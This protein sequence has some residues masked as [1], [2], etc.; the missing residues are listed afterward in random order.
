LL[1][2]QSRFNKWRS[3]RGG[4][5][6]GDIYVNAMVEPRTADEGIFARLRRAKALVEA[7]D[8]DAATLQFLQLLDCD[9]DGPLRGEVLT[10]LGAALCLSARG[11]PDATAIAQLNHARE[12]LAAAIDCRPRRQAPAA[13]ATTRANLALVYL[14]R[15]QVTDNRDDLMAAHLALDGTEQGLRE[16]GGDT[17]LHDWVRAIRDQLVELSE[18]RAIR[19]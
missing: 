3:I 11:R 14:A 2:N 1:L 16:G 13:W 9:L 10:N 17:A 6:K 15:Y 18:R 5:T 8:F 12:L 7:N 4:R 19:R